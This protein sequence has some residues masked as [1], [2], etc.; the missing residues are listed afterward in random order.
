MLAAV[1]VVEDKFDNLAVLE[2][3]GVR[4]G[5]VDGGIGSIVSGGEHGVESGHLGRDV[6]LVVDEST[7]KKEMSKRGIISLDSDGLTSLLHYPSYPSSWSFPWCRMDSSKVLPSSRVPGRSRHM[8][9]R[10]RGLLQEPVL[11]AHHIAA[12]QSHSD[13]KFPGSCQKGPGTCQKFQ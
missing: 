7:S 3:V 10:Y 12:K 1:G 4:V 11:S 6:C 9:Q 8:V 13:S 2:D 5:S